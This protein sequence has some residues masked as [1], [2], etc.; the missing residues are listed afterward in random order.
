MPSNLLVIMSDEHQARALGCAGHPFVKTP[1]LDRL[2]AR[3]MQ[4]TDAYTPSPICVPARASFATGRYAHQTR[5]WDNAMPY[6][7]NPKGW[8]HALQAKGVPVESIGKLHYRDTSDAAGFDVE[9]IPM[10]VANGVG[11]VWGS[12]RKEDERIPT[13]GGRRM[14]GDYIG[15]GH[16]KYTQYDASVTQCTKDWLDARATSKDDQ[17]WCL[18]VGLVAP[19][20]PLV[21]PQEFYDL[22][23]TVDLP[24]VKLH[25]E[26]GY[27]RHP[28]VEKQDAVMESETK[29]N[30]PEERLQ[31][32]AAYY[33]LCSWL[34]HNVGQ[35]LTALDDAGMTEDTTIVYTSDHGDNVGA[36][37]LW[38]KSNFYQESVH[39]PMIMAGPDVPQ[40]TCTTPVSL[41]DLSQTIAAH[42]G[43]DIDGAAG[44]QSLKDIAAS[45]TD[46]DRAVFSE[47]HAIG[48]VS[49]GFMLRKGRWK[50]NYYVGFE[51]ELFDLEN[52]PQELIDLA[53]DP[54]YA[55]TLDKLETALR[56]ICDP[57]AVD[58]QAFE[59]QAALIEYHGGRE[60]ALKL[61][62]PGATPPPLS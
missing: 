44:I 47:Y 50:L 15:P 17:P 33:G 43:T 11:M 37:G 4:F 29:F 14:L 12:I 16:S 55:D 38:G 10:H 49:G 52:D 30:T 7:G 27:R 53:P 22:Y 31:A 35:I 61:G 18:Y 46:P 1:N 60:A 32:M 58:A 19:H 25:P 8:G 23:K 39:I 26:T 21:A 48:A 45:Q 3:G 57:E 34:D 41:L 56:Q 40:G 62:A 51:P 20:F 28:W 5:L 2:A 59:D 24:E 42:F 6:T 13:P 54:S 36:R 9:H